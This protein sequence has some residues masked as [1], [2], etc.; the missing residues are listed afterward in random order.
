MLWVIDKRDRASH[1]PVA[2]S[3]NAPFMSL[4]DMHREPFES[5]LLVYINCYRLCGYDVSE[6]S[7]V[8][9]ITRSGREW[10]TRRLRTSLHAQF[11]ER[12]TNQPCDVT[13]AVSGDVGH[14]WSCGHV[15]PISGVPS[16][17]WPQPSTFLIRSSTGWPPPWVWTIATRRRASARFS[18]SSSTVTT[19]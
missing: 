1:S 19:S 10:L 11:F 18:R 7:T 2:E 3:K 15:R 17:F 8:R 5:V 16:Q 4:V 12:K 13:Y 9:I 14:L 6:F